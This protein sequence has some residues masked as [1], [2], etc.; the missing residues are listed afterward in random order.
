MVFCQLLSKPS[1]FCLFCH[2]QFELN[3]KKKKKLKKLTC[4]YKNCLR[5]I[6]FLNLTYRKTTQIYKMPCF[7]GT[8]WENLDRVIV[9]LPW[10]YDKILCVWH[11]IINRNSTVINMKSIKQSL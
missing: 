4:K 6:D 1:Q 7:I 3:M 9:Y 5:T 8:L 11:A 10:L 2:V